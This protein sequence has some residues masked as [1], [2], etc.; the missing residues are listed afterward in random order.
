MQIADRKVVTSCLNLDARYNSFKNVFSR[1]HIAAGRLVSSNIAGI[2]VDG[3]MA[4]DRID[5]S[6]AGATIRFTLFSELS[7]SGSIHGRI[8]VSRLSHSLTGDSLVIGEFSIQPDGYTDIT[9]ETGN[10]VFELEYAAQPIVFHF[11]LEA[12]KK[13]ITGKP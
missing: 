2:K 12:L 10:E 13:P 6:M 4:K 9:G 3:D 8:I 1:F 5:V 11:I 7:D